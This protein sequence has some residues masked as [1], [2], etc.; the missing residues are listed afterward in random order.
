M[1]PL[2]SQ[3]WQFDHPDTS[4]SWDSPQ[5]TSH[6]KGKTYRQKHSRVPA[7]PL[8]KTVKGQQAD[9]HPPMHIELPA[10]WRASPDYDKTAQNLLI[11]EAGL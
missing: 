1:S 11:L 7:E 8:P 4:S 3:C 9:R 5:K 6:H 2:S 10:S